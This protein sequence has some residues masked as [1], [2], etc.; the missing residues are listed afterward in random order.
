[1][2][3][4]TEIVGP[5]ITPIGFDDRVPFLHAPPRKDRS[6]GT[7]RVLTGCTPADPALPDS[8]GL[9]PKLV[10]APGFADG[11]GGWVDPTAGTEGSVSFPLE[12]GRHL[13][14]IACASIDGYPLTVTV[15]VD[16]TELITHTAECGVMAQDDFT[17]VTS[18]SAP[19]DAPS[20]DTVRS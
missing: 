13:L 4:R 20:G 3:T 2:I 1:M 10:Q 7:G 12:A 8:G 15:T 19:F 14:R 5:V 11:A 16:G 18:E 17:A 6:G 9:D